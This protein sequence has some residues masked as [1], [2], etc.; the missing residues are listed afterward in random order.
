M[1]PHGAL[2]LLFCAALATACSS[3]SRNSK[4]VVV[5][6]APAAANASAATSAAAATGTASAVDP[7]LVKE[8]YKVVRRHGEILY[9]QTQ[10]ITGTK[11]G[12][13]VCKTA[14]QIQELKRETER[15]KRLLI[16][17]GPANCVGTQCS[18]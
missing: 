16:R 17:S 1:R 10:T 13:T 11:F 9:C 7:D 15:S 5:A 8:G 18:N 6:Q 3:Q 2:A 14:G 12:N 4:P